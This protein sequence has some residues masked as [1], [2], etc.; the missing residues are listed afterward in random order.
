MFFP[1]LFHLLI[2]IMRG[3]I[4]LRIRVEKMVKKDLLKLFKKYGF[5]SS[6]KEPFLYDS[7]E[8]L[9][10]YYTFK[11]ENYG[12][13]NRVFLPA[14]EEEAEWFLKNYYAYKVAHC[15]V[16]KLSSYS[17]IFAKPIFEENIEVLDENSYELFYDEP[18][19]RSAKLIIKIIEEKMALSL[20]TYENVKRLTEK[21]TKVKQELWQKLNKK[22]VDVSEFNPALLLKIKEQQQAILTDLNNS[23]ASCKSKNDFKVLIDDLISYLRSLELEDSLVNNKYFMLKIPIEIE[24]LKEE[25]SLIDEYAKIKLKKKQKLELESRL[26]QLQEK[27]AKNKIVS[28]GSF[29]KDEE[30]RVNEKYNMIS[31]IDYDS[32]ADYLIEFDNLKINEEV[33]VLEKQGL[34]ILNDKFMQLDDKDKNTLYLATFFQY[35]LGNYDKYMVSDYYKMILNPNN[36]L[37][38]IRVFKDIDVSSLSNFEKS[39]NDC[40]KKIEKI[41]K[42]VMPC[43]IK[44]YFK[45]DRNI[46]SNLIIASSKKACMPKF[47]SDEPCYYIMMLKKGSVINFVPSKL[48][49]L[50]TND[51]KI[52]LKDGNPLFI[53]DLEKNKFISDNNGIIKVVN[54]KIDGKA[55]TDI[56]TVTKVKIDKIDYYKNV[57]VER[58][59]NNG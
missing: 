24:Q 8:G 40:F 55:T 30:R 51:D 6:L 58:M 53:I 37:A 23:L 34:K 13:L 43:D 26:K 3:I 29:V 52:V 56:V 32:I 33:N 45:T 39:I 5:D 18:Y 57:V 27:H 42:I 28:L 41:P 54:V 19:C 4:V 2:S 50:V 14:T 21:Y 36:V 20:L 59:D 38:K 15:N 47:D 12:S 10:I 1:Y 22:S 44:L 11:D 31:D 25:I 17:D 9:G 16:I 48:T 7:K 49:N 46:T 35:F